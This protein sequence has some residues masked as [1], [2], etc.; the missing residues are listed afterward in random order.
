MVLAGLP[1][2]AATLLG[3]LLRASETFGVRL[4]ELYAVLPDDR[5]EAYPAA[6]RPQAWVAA[7]AGVVAWALA[8]VIP[9][10]SR[11][12]VTTLAPARLVEQA[13]V[14]GLAV[15]GPATSP[16]LRATRWWSHRGKR[17]GSSATGHGGCS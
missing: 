12:G 17:T 10:D 1:E 11:A 7:A 4:P 6:C 5:V 16:P 15:G 3:G 14:H 13:T 2:H 9:D 8:P